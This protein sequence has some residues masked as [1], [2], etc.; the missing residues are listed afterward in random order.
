MSKL[1]ENIEGV[2]DLAS[3]IAEVE[4]KSHRKRQIY[5][6]SKDYVP[7]S[8][9]SASGS[10]PLKFYESLAAVT[11]ILL[12]LALLTLTIDTLIN[13]INDFKN[14]ALF[15]R[16]CHHF[17]MQQPPARSLNSTSCRRA[18]KQSITRLN[19]PENANDSNESD[20][21]HLVSVNQLIDQS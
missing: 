13:Q 14:L 17:L 4:D 9:Q 20:H 5:H 12:S 2:R 1:D 10:I 15:S 18:H 16:E 6:R 19:H 3:A 7:E 11:C 8:V 21:L